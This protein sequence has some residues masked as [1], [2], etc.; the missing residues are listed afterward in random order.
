MYT[1]IEY[2][3]FIE[4]KHAHCSDDVRI[5]CQLEIGFDVLY[6]ESEA[7]VCVWVQ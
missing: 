5:L 2:T 3:Y 6:I 1:S 7:H 4:W